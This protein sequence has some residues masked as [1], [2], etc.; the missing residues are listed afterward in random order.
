MNM[1]KKGQPSNPVILKTITSNVV[2][3]HALVGLFSQM[4]PN[5]KSL[6]NEISLNQDA[7]I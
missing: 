6:V 2:M 3:T 5:S 1:L 7:F 4:Q